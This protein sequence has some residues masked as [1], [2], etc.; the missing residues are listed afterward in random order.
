MCGWGAVADEQ[1]CIAST[2]RGSRPCHAPDSE[3]HEAAAPQHSCIAFDAMLYG[4]CRWVRHRLE[5]LGFTV[6]CFSSVHEAMLTLLKDKCIIV[7]L[8]TA[9][10]SRGTGLKVK[11]PYR[12][13]ANSGKL[14]RRFYEEWWTMLMR[15]LA[16]IGVVKHHIGYKRAK[17]GHH[18]G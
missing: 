3:M 1:P 16:E 2:A 17:P 13:R 8:D 9:Y 4:F 10:A 6:Y 11:L 14:K 7:T 18:Q 12:M 15:Q 5:L